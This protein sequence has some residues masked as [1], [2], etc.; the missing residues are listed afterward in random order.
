MFSQEK[1]DFW[2]ALIAGAGTTGTTT[3]TAGTN[4]VNNANTDV[5]N[6]G[7]T[8]VDTQGVATGTGTAAT[9]TGTGTRARTVAAPAPSPDVSLT[10]DLTCWVQVVYALHENAHLET[11]HTSDWHLA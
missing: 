9:A 6:N 10:P 5:V 3:G 7:N 11:Q 1:P 8:N 2:P 4:T